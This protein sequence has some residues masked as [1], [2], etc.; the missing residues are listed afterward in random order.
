MSKGKTF[1][2]YQIFVIAIL[3][4][5]QFTIV[6]DFMVISPLSAILLEELSISTSQFG[7]LVSAYAF[8]AGA[9]GILAS[10]FADNFDRKKWLLFFYAGFIGGT[11]FCGLAN[12]YES[13]LSARIVTGIFGGV[14]SSISYAIIT[15]LFELK[16][17][18]RVMGF[19]QMAFAVSQVFGIPL[20]LFLANK[21]D[22]HAPFL[23]I[24]IVS[25]L[26]ALPI[27]FFM[28]PVRKHLEQQS[29]R[30]PFR[31]MMGILRN[32]NYLKGFTL[33]A[34]LTTGGF[35]LMPFAAAFTVNNLGITLEQLPLVY[36][37]TGIFA[38]AM[39]PVAGKLSDQHGKLEIF[40]YG[41][42][43]AITSLLIYCNLGI[44]PLWL[45]ILMNVVIFTGITARG[46]SSQALITAVP[47][48]KDRGAFMSINSSVMQVA[49][50]I[51]AWIAGMIVVQKESGKLLHY[52]TLGYVVSVTMII[53]IGLLYAVNRIVFEKNKSE[54]TFSED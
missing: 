29:K 33:T 24:V 42:L 43:I 25:I 41:S 1:S 54:T 23:F 51:A 50:G 10:G 12:S 36:L 15:D 9:G 26:V 19:V 31:H 22:W 20:G 47:Q 45:V 17:R 49:G 39:G 3:S 52:D 44:T 34:F 13:L 35:M 28:K 21:M 27:V 32:K 6:L 7:L 4:I 40:A 2:S 46:V 8:S 48:I 16:K 5:L 14:L 37:I 53:T 11:L 30:H 18:G 38:M